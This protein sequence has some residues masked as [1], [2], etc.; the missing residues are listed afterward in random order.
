MKTITIY[1]FDHY[2]F[3]KGVPIKARRKYNKLYK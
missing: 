1:D 3:G 2:D